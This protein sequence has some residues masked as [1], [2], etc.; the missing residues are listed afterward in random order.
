MITPTL[1]LLFLFTYLPIYG[2]IISFQDY[3]IGNNILSFSENIK[4]VGLKHF[5]EFFNSIFFTRVFGNTIRLSVLNLLFGFWVPIVFAI[6]LNEVRH[7]LYKRLTQTFVY[8]PHFVSV[9]VVVA[10]IMSMTGPNGFIGKLY[11]FFTGKSVNMINNARYF[12]TL[13]IS[14]GIWQNFGYSAIIYIA[15]IASIDPTLYEAAIVD[16]ANRFRRIIHITFPGIL[17]TIVILLI[18]A[19]GGLLN[20]N[21]EKILLMKNPNTAPKA[22]VIGTYVYQVGLRDGRYSFTAAVGLFSNVINFVLV[23]CANTISRRIGG[24]S[25]W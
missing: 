16:G 13:Y 12:D 2:I 24:A 1:L 25:L 21:T 7:P 22:E 6:L 15:A 20:A 17:P 9:V 14:S 18:L 10:L 11:T 3:K 19:I 4:W 5:T 23:F 8:L